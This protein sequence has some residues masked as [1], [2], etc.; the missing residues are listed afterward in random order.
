MVASPDGKWLY[1][2]GFCFNWPRNPPFVSWVHAVTRMPYDGNKTPTLWAGDLAEGKSS[3]EEGKFRMPT[4]VACDTS[5]RVYV[6]DYMND[7]VQ[8]FSP[9]GKVANVV[10]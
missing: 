7:R 4:S 3:K 1:L 8:I 9:E 5:G 2:T 6:S 10:G